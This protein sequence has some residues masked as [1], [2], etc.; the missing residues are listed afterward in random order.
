ML[1]TATETTGSKQKDDS[2]TFPLPPNQTSTKLEICS[3][4][5]PLT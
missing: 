4:R 2:S 5:A 1:K 3:S